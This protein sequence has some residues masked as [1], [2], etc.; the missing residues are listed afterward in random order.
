LDSEITGTI[1]QLQKTEDWLYDE[2]E[3]VQK[4]EYLIKQENLNS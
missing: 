1:D 4:D 2:G 3:N